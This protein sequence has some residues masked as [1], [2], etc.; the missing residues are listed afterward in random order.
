MLEFNTQG[1]LTPASIIKSS[2]GELEEYFVIDSP[3][4]VRKDLYGQYIK[5][6]SDLKEVCGNVEFTQW[7]DGSFVTKKPKPADIDLVTFIQLEVAETRERELKQFIYPASLANYQID[8]YI[9]VVYPE[10][11]KLHFTYKADC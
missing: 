11:H 2:P 6:N 4:N 9:V 10:N 3:E 5:Y 7:L 8:G 1:L